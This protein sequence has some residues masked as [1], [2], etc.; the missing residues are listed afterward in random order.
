MLSKI[1]LQ[2]YIIVPD[3]DL[4]IVTAELITH[5]KLS[6]AEVG[7][8]HF[9]VTL[10]ENNPNKFNVYEEFVDQMSFDKHQSRVKN[11]HWGKVTKRVERHYTIS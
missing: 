11:S 2:G 9:R 5:T 7:C 3:V 1:T 10:D 8:L 4:K 6:K